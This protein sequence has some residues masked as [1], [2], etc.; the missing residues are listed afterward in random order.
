MKQNSKANLIIWYIIG[1]IAL[2]TIILKLTDTLGILEVSIDAW[3]GYGLSGLLFLSAICQIVAFKQMNTI[4]YRNTVSEE[5]EAVVK[6]FEAAKVKMSEEGIDQWDEVYPNVNDIS[7]DIK[8]NQMYTVYMGNKLAGV[9]VVNAEADK[10]YKFGSW[11]DTDGKYAV[12]HRLCVAP[13]YQ[14]TGIATKIMEHIE[15]EQKKLGVTSIRLDVFSKNPYALGLYEK[16]GYQNV[17]D[18]YWRK[19]RFYLMEKIIL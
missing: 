15:A 10:A 2:L 14:H 7:N 9:Y 13:E 17:G 19:G 5:Q 3:T 6:L 18:A 12:V 16:L 11:T 1:A 4:Y 8:N